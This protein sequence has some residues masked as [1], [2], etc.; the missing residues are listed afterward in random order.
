MGKPVPSSQREPQEDSVR[1]GHPPS[2]TLLPD[3][4]P[5]PLGPPMWT[6]TQPLEASPPFSPLTRNQAGL[7]VAFLLKTLLTP[8]P[9]P[10]QLH[11]ARPWARSS[12]CGSS[13]MT[14]LVSQVRREHLFSQVGLDLQYPQAL[15]RALTPSLKCHTCH[16]PHLWAVTMTTAITATPI[17]WTPGD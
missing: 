1:M 11:I 12:S 10:H 13:E 7:T 5:R 8:H 16:P 9:L 17:P 6:P 2:P 4:G 14:R 3:P 15:L